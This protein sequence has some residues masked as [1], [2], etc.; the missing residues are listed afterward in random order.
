MRRD[1]AFFDRCDEARKT[2][3]VKSGVKDDDMA[4]NQEKKKKEKKRMFRV[5]VRAHSAQNKRQK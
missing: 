4:G 5:L 2:E 1:W 3:N